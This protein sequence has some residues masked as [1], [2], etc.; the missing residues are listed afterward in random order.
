MRTWCEIR[1][2]ASQKFGLT[3]EPGSLFNFGNSRS[4][5]GHYG[6]TDDCSWSLNRRRIFKFEKLPDPDSKILEQERCRSL[7]KWLRPPLSC[8]EGWAWARVNIKPP[9]KPE[10]EE[11]FHQNAGCKYRIVLKILMVIRRFAPKERSVS[12]L[13]CIVL[14]RSYIWQEFNGQRK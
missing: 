5:C 2:F 7:N 9:E 6:W 11:M 8:T 4:L 1:N 3:P 10:T 12:H 13:Y 14:F